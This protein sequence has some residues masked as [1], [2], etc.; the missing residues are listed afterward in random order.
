MCL[1]HPSHGWGA[2]VVCVLKA[3]H[4]QCAEG[5]IVGQGSKRTLRVVLGFWLSC[6]F[7]TWESEGGSLEWKWCVALCWLCCSG[8]QTLSGV[9]KMVAEYASQRSSAGGSCVWVVLNATK[10]LKYQGSE[11]KK[12]QEGNDLSPEV[13]LAF[14]NHR[15]DKYQ[16]RPERIP[17]EQSKEKYVPQS[18]KSPGRKGA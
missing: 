16:Q 11:C 8:C 3:S 5:S 14:K 17:G 9:L 10:W 2:L 1:S 6:L 4:P 7:L 18:K 12:E 15:S 13:L